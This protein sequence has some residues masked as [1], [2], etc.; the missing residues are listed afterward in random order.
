VN[1]P[2]K[3][4]SEIVSKNISDISYGQDLTFTIT[5]R[6]KDFV[7]PNQPLAL[8][9]VFDLI[10]R[11]VDDED[12]NQKLKEMDEAF[13]KALQKLNEKSKLAYELSKISDKFGNEALITMTDTKKAAAYVNALRDTYF[14]SMKQYS[15]TGSRK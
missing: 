2:V 14:E 8:E 1:E 3:N 7:N 12:H 10:D 4:I 11:Q 6:L 13:F 5:E 9:W 15:E